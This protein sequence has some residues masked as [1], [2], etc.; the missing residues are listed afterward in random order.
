MFYVFEAKDI[1]VGVVLVML[2]VIKAGK[3]TIG[4]F[5]RVLGFLQTMF[6]PIILFRLFKLG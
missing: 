2:I 6:N 5:V 1:L 4:L 3:H